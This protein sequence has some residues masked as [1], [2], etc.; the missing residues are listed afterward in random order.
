MFYQSIGA[1]INMSFTLVV[2]A[3][4]M[5]GGYFRFDS[6]AF[7]LGLRAFRFS[8]NLHIICHLLTYKD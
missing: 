5:R 2:E 1:S 8:K 4:R 3:L 7:I 6:A